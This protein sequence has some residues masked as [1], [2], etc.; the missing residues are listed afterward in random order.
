MLLM[1]VTRRIAA[2]AFFLTLICLAFPQPGQAA[3]G[4]RA[5][6]QPHNA[7]G[8]TGREDLVAA[9]RDRG[10]VRVIVGLQTPREMAEGSD[11][12]PD[13][14]KER[15]VTDRQERVLERLARHGV[16]QLKRLRHHP[17]MAVTLDAAAM[18]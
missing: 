16:R 12:T 1:L 7:F 11:S 10:E 17:F 3:A 6:K 15:R 14:V 9:L 13:H 8:K 2:A 18:A 5:I 4:D